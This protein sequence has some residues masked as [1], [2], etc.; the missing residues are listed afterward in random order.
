[1]AVLRIGDRA[2]DFIA[3]S[4]HGEIH[5][6]DWLGSSWGILFSHPED[7]TPVCTTELSLLAQLQPEFE[8]R[9]T[10]II[11]VSVDGLASHYDWIK[12]INENFNTQIQFPLIA[13][14]QRALAVYYGMIHPSENDTRTVRDVFIISPLKEIKAT[15]TYPASTGRHFDEIIRLLDSTQLHYH[16]N[17]F[18][19]AIWRQ[20][21]DAIIDPKITG[22]F[23]NF[24]YPQGH[25]VVTDYLRFI[26]D[27][28]NGMVETESSDDQ[29]FENLVTRVKHL[30]EKEK[31]MATKLI[32]RFLEKIDL[33]RIQ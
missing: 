30:P 4:T 22:D 19:P 3:T 7:F 27:Q 32:A 17:L 12:D 5:F 2:P 29:N 14:T 11:G 24:L 31:K 18:T 33:E 26:H 16:K 21:D 28:R 9:N 25:K 13:D 10:K 15:L 8:K 6:H 1:M 23:A 20:G